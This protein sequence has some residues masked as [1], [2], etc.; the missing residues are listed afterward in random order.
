MSILLLWLAINTAPDTL[1]V[2]GQSAAVDV[3]SYG[4]IL[5]AN[6]TQA[7]RIPCIVPFET[8]DA[9][10]VTSL[11]GNR[12]HPILHRMR[13]HNGLD[14]GC[15]VQPVVASARGV[16]SRTG[17]DARG[18]GNYV[19]IIHGNGYETTY[20]HLSEVW[21]RV[22]Q[23]LNLSQPLGMAGKTGL[24]TGVHLHYEIRKHGRLAD[25]LDYLLLLYRQ[26]ET[27]LR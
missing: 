1:N 21:V 12:Y 11:F 24:A 7:L 19:K 10:M 20:G 13:S 4:R 3:A 14:I 18:L 26:A 22:G 6:P 9:T 5:T 25:P 8:Y 2:A 17:F 16:V 27:T 15:A 23:I